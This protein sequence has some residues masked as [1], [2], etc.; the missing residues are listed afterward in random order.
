MNPTAVSGSTLWKR[1]P[2]CDFNSPSGNVRFGAVDDYRLGCQPHPV[3]L[4]SDLVR[5]V[6]VRLGSPHEHATSRSSPIRCDRLE[7][8]ADLRT[9]RRR[10]RR[11]CTGMRRRNGL[12][13]RSRPRSTVRSTSLT[14]RTATAR[15]AR[16]ISA[17]VQR[18][19]GYRM[20]YR[21]TPSV[22]GRASRTRPAW[23]P[24]QDP[25]SLKSIDHSR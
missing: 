5:L 17:V 13:P 23:S 25:D 19:G 8:Y 4:P 9:S 2:A 10:T 18:R 15:T 7:G 21:G 6:V 1:P 24:D 16:R 11:I 22:F 3:Q 20:A 12:S 14:H